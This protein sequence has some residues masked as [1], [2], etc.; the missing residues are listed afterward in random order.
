MGFL[1]PPPGAA[2]HARRARWPPTL[3]LPFARS[4]LGYEH[5]FGRSKATPEAEPVVGSITLSGEGRAALLEGISEPAFE[6]PEPAFA[7]VV[8]VGFG[9]VLSR[10]SRSYRVM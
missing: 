10:P 1:W 2:V 7:V 6:V 5:E 3:L 9:P 4:S 8:T